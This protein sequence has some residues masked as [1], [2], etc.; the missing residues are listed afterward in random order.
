MPLRLEAIKFNHDPSSASIDAFNIRKNER[1]FVEA[2]EWRRGVSINP[3]DSPAAYALFETRGNTLT[4]QAS[5][6]CEDRR[7]DSVDIR[8]VDGRSCPK[9]VADFLGSELVAELL[10]PL[11]GSTE[12]LLGEIEARNVKLSNGT[13][14]FKTFNL[15]NVR[16][17]DVG[18]GVQDIV[19]RWQFRLRPYDAWVDFATS[20]H[21]IYTTLGKPREPWQQG[22]FNSSNVQ[23]PWAA[24]LEYACRWAASAQ[25]P[26]D[27]ATRITRS[28]YQ[29]GKDGIARYCAK[30]QYALPIVNDFR[31]A[32]FLFDLKL[33]S[34][35]LNCTDCATIVST[36]ANILGA[37]LWQ[38]ETTDFNHNPV[39]LIGESKWQE[40]HFSFHV[41]AWEED[42]DFHN[43]VFDACLQIDADKDPTNSD[44][45]HVPLLPTDLRF[46]RQ[47]EDLYR[48]R[49]V[50][51]NDPP[52]AGKPRP[53]VR[54]RRPIEVP[55][56]KEQSRLSPELLTFASDSFELEAFLNNGLAKDKRFFKCVT[57]DSD[58][59]KDW[60]KLRSERLET[61]KNSALYESLWRSLDGDAMLLI[62]IYEGASD[63]A[64]QEWFRNSIA[65]LHSFKDVSKVN[66]S[67]ADAFLI[68]GD[69][70][71]ITFLIAN[72]AI[73]LVNVGKHPF[74]VELIAQDL[75]QQLTVN[76]ADDSSSHS[77]RIA[78]EASPQ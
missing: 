27:A 44:Q 33:G 58:F 52:G 17:W 76:I 39:L 64:A 26:T 38:S 59:L 53:C 1:E 24:V 61:D 35:R 47:N 36:F 3:E 55:P 67:F 56:L 69:C 16:I 60:T 66:D 13:S 4:I 74:P 72:L 21:R 22:P 43:D 70:C 15:K 75:F 10:Q 57:P 65:A 23:L 29:L 48:D 30:A 34:M 49:V 14:G 40:G 32:Q 46:G 9:H 71:G 11:F 25:N 5:F 62:N 73:S 31:C 68:L 7:V 2:P 42:C 18:V 51:P 50:A 28:V 19:W 41:V 8:A 20:T 6:S 78:G 54:I 63:Q 37:E 12:N 45:C 77:E